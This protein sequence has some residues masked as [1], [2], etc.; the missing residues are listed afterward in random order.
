[1]DFT[2]YLPHNSDFEP[3][4]CAAYFE[5]NG[6][7][8][9]ISSDYTDDNLKISVRDPKTEKSFHFASY[10]MDRANY[11]QAL[12]EH[13]KYKEALKKCNAHA[14]ITAKTQ[15][16][17]AL[18]ITLLSYLHKKHSAKIFNEYNERPLGAKKLADLREKSINDYLSTKHI[19]LKDLVSKYH[20]PKLIFSAILLIAYFIFN[21]KVD[22]GTDMFFF[23]IVIGIIILWVHD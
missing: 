15:S 18:A 5:E 19:K 21:A 3:K 22:Y 23:L 11:R 16:A 2:C 4:D 8:V 10:K 12:E 13:S 7:K 17:H 9:I 6:L 1:M 20:L 14:S